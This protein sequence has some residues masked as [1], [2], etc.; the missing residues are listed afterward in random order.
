MD[1][2]FGPPFAERVKDFPCIAL[3][4]AASGHPGGWRVVRETERGMD[5][6]EGSTGKRIL[7]KTHES[8]TQRAEK[9]NA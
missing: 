8:A 3:W 9:L 4:H 6:L 7:F 1:Y 5:E 2:V